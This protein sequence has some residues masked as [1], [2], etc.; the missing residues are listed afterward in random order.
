M[1]IS[2]HGRREKTSGSSQW[3]VGVG[4]RP[5][6]PPPAREPQH[7][8][9]HTLRP[10]IGHL[11]FRFV[12]DETRQKQDCNLHGTGCPA[13]QEPSRVRCHAPLPMPCPHAYPGVRTMRIRSALR[14]GGTHTHLPLVH[15]PTLPRTHTCVLGC[16]FQYFITTQT[17]VW[18]PPCD[19]CNHKEEGE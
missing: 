12:S 10:T 18:F 5:V 11:A 3:F 2:C 17:Q 15:L 4:P 16:M 9:T 19:A 1:L 13:P 8:H 6:C 14:R 7:T